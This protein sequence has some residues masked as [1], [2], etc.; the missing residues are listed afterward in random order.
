MKSIYKGVLLFL[1]WAVGAL[2]PVA[3]AQAQPEN[4]NW[5]FGN[6]AGVSFTAPVPVA[7]SANAMT[8]CEGS[9]SVSTTTGQLAMYSNGE[10]VWD[11][12]HQVMPDGAGLGGHN[13]AS[14][15]AL[16]LPAPGS[17]TR[18]YLF[19]GDAIANNLAGGRQYSLLDVSL[20]D[21]RANVVVGRGGVR[22]PPPTGKVTEKLTAALHANGRDYWG[23][24]T[25]GNRMPATAFCSPPAASAPRPP[26]AP[27]DPAM[28]EEAALTGP[29]MPLAP[30]AGRP[31]GQ[32]WRW[33]S[34][35]PRLSSTTSTTPPVPYQTC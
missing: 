15:A 13:P 18:Y 17:A 32:S 16:I 14:Q 26:L 4:G 8:S 2:C 23:W 30:C 31:T 19:T 22:L 7:L 27:S 5:Y 35:A 34:A 12:A 20:H 25:A 3:S 21:G 29:P 28:R 1:G 6:Q 9:A 24:C 33:P 10:Q 11:T